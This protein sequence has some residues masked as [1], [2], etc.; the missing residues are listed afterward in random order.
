MAR[1]FAKKLRSRRAKKKPEQR[2]PFHF[3]GEAH[4]LSA[5]FHRPIYFPIE[6]QASVS[7]PTIGG[8]ARSRVENFVGD[9]LVRFTSAHCHV[10]GSW[11]NEKVATTHATATIEGLNILDF[12]TAERIVARLT[13]EHRVGDPEGHFI[14]LGSSFEGLKIAG[15]DVKVTLRHELF[16]KSKTF[17]ALRV[18]LARDREPDKITDI[19][20]DRVALCSLA[21]D[22][23]VEF[24]G[25][26]K[27]G[28]I[29]TIEHF[30]EIAIAEVFAAFGTR[31]LTMLRFRLGS[32][33]GGS[34]TV[35]EATTNGQPYPPVPSGS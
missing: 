31:T 6:A 26:E 12:V 28:H 1:K 18:H 16:V 25:L 24:P 14:A 9:H 8:H 20:T 23:D 19:T 13:S 35:T 11:M 3:H 32:P 30:G 5:R 15:H 2:I 17:G 33:S 22:I 34:G 7:L 10:S 4:A 27:R 29:L 21:E